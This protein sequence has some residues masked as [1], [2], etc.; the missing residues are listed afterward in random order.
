MVHWTRMRDGSSIISFG[1]SHHRPREETNGDTIYLSYRA[2]CMYIGNC[3]SLHIWGRHPTLLS[4]SLASYDPSTHWLGTNR[5]R[6]DTCKTIGKNRKGKYATGHG[7]IQ[8]I[9]ERDIPSTDY[10][11]Q[12]ARL[13]RWK[14]RVL[15]AES[16]HAP[17][18]HT[19][20]RRP[21]PATLRM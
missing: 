13:A 17:Q 9:Y 11:S 16:K 5:V 14:R 12:R 7:P 2:V 20:W 19:R 4:M 8:L 10:E 15:A 6:M 21:P 3:C 18:R 1:W